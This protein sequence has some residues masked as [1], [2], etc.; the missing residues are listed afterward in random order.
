MKYE[1]TIERN[2][3]KALEKIPTVDRNKIVRFI[4]SLENNPRPVGVKKL[5]GRDGWRI[6]IG[7]YRVIYEIED[8]ICHILILDV[9]HRKDIYR[10]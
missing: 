8:R 2:A 7:R 5:I 3:L 9:G 10:S 4:E 6:R 1:I